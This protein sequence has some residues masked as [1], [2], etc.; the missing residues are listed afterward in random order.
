MDFDAF[1]RQLEKA[2]T[3]LTAR[4]KELFELNK[5]QGMPVAEIAQLLNITEQTIYNQL[6]SALKILRKEIGAVHL[7]LF[8][9][10]F[11]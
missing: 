3:K 9:S 8:L 4:Q 10:F 11:G 1:S 7:I 5:E 2:K 6:S